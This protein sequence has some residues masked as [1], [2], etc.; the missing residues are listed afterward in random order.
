[1]D[2]LIRPLEPASETPP[3][4]EGATTGTG[5][6]EIRV[7]GKGLSVPSVQID[8][9]TVFTTAKWL[10]IAAVRDEELIEGQTVT[11]PE[12]F[13]S[14]LKASCLK[15]DLFTFAQRLP[16]KA[17]MYGYHVEWEDAAVIPITTFE[18]WWEECTEYSIRKAVN[19]AKKLGVTV[20]VADFSDQFVEAICRVYSETPVRQGKAFWHYKKDFQSVKRELATYLDRSIFIGAYYKDEL[21]G[22]MKITCVG[23]TAAIMQIFCAS[24]HFDKRPNNALIAKAIEICEL[25]NK[26]YLIYGSFVYYDPNS[27]LTEFKRRNGFEPVALPR[28]YIPLTLKGRLAL[29]LGLHRGILGNVPKPALR[30]FLRIRRI[31]YGYRSKVVGT[32]QRLPV[33]AVL[34]ARR[35]RE[36]GGARS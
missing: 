24:Q 2:M 8:G 23:P 31:W 12:S 36:R 34:I 27:T 32:L 6:T 35:Q 18:R 29:K 16:D 30:Q 1:M 7:K 25:E 10:S 21:I 17:P 14:R 11:N 19:R 20:K 15:A 33:A 4:P 22:S 3:E 26:A 28:Y 9:Q 13:I 5:R